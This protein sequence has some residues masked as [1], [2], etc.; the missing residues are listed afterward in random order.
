M[1]ETYEAVDGKLRI[2]VD[3]P[4]RDV[5]YKALLKEKNL[6]LQA[7]MAVNTLN[8]RNAQAA[9]A[10]YDKALSRIVEAEKLAL[11]VLVEEPVDT[12]IDA[13]ESEVIAP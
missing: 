8:A 6:A 7:L 13:E 10:R 9:Q 4:T 11:N 1:A 12:D 5:D 2:K 3:G